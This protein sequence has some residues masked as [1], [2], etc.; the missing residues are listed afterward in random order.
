MVQLQ[1]HLIGHFGGECPVG[2]RL[3]EQM[4]RGAVIEIRFLEEEGLA[5]VVVGQVPEVF[6]SKGQR[7]DRPLVGMARR[8]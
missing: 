3:F 6:G 4:K 2:L 1:E 8:E 5:D 7:I